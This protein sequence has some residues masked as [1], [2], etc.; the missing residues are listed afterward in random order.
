MAEADYPLLVFPE[1]AH[2]AS[3]PIRP[4]KPSRRGVA[5][6]GAGALGGANAVPG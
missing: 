1:P 6:R 4:Y 3:N 5:G 2:Q